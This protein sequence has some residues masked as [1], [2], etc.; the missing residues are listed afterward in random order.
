M[1]IG[2]ATGFAAVLLV[3]L[4]AAPAASAQVQVPPPEIG[5]GSPNDIE[6]RTLKFSGNKA[7]T[8]YA[9]ERGIATT[10]STW[11]RRMFKVIGQKYCLDSLHTLV[12]D[13]ARLDFLYRRTGFPDI[14]IKPM[15]RQLGGRKVAVEYQIT[16]GQPMLL[17]SV[18][19][20][21]E[22]AVDDS[23]RFTDDLPVEAGDRFDL[24]VLE[25]TRDTIRTRL[26]NRGYPDPYILRN[27]DQ[28]PSEHR[29][30]VQYVIMPGPKSWIGKINIPPPAPVDTSR[31]ARISTDRV[32]EV[33][34]VDEGDLYNES[35][36]QRAGR[37]L[38]QTEAFRFVGVSVDTATLSDQDSLVNVN[39]SL[40][41]SELLATRASIG[42]AN[43]DCLRAQ[44]NHTNYNFLGLRRLDLNARVSKV[45]TSSPTEWAQGLCTRELLNDEVSDTLNYYL[46]TTISQAALFGLRIVPSFSVY[47]ERRS[48][49]KAYLRETPVGVIASAQQGFGTQLPMTWS[50]QLE[51]GRTTAQ[52]AFF[53]AVFNV[54]ETDVR[55]RLERY[56]RS[57]VVGWAA[58]RSRV[59]SPSSPTSGTIA[60]LDLRHA[61]PVVGA[62]K[63]ASFNRATFD[64]TYYTPAMGG[65]FVARIR[66]GTVLGARL[67]L[68]GSSTPTFIPLQERLYAGGPNSVRGFR[69]NEMGPAIYIPNRFDSTTVPGHD[70]LQFW[71]SDPNLVNERTV[72]TGGDNVIVANAELR[73]RA[74]AYPELVQYALFVDAGQVWNRGRAGTGVNF[75][76]IRVTPGI[77]LR[78]FTPIGPVRV[79]VGYNPYRRSS[80]PAYITDPS[81]NLICV[82]PGNTLRVL[83]KEGEPPRQIDGGDCPATY[84]P[85]FGT[86]FWNRLTFQF[87]I[88]QP[89]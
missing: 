57:A 73:L 72:P 6:V 55:E 66:A 50:Y 5:C 4:A 88:G 83:V 16:E 69:Q 24:V 32:R 49:F 86:N 27:F 67:D 12:I 47:S 2:R 21:W 59:N 30:T 84:V 36:L 85:R 38:F 26:A 62:T 64:A 75:A 43:L 34:G 41:E 40:S 17:D 13:S 19:I 14:R 46:G 3:G 31:A 79:D 77:G 15:I 89:F 87:S 74:P 37:S 54:C 23:S 11:W 68:S 10:A 80:G 60:R 58:T 53:C 25:A 8:S 22:Q 71:R 76:D 65:T 20:V 33:L 52:P 56:T 35:A 28:Y 81:G 45:G 9:L 82:S 39:V 7:H 29:A 51:Y 70:T 78:V 44:V 48:E 1:N 61:S 42:W 18:T 63:D